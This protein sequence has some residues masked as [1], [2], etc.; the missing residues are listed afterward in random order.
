M[1]MLESNTP[2]ESPV[3]RVSVNTNTVTKV[4]I[5][6]P[7][8]FEAIRFANPPCRLR[9]PMSISCNTIVLVVGGLSAV[10]VRSVGTIILGLDVLAF[11]LVP[12]TQALVVSKDCNIFPGGRVPVG[13]V[14]TLFSALKPVTVAIIVLA[15]RHSTSTVIQSLI[16]NKEALI[17]GAQSARHIVAKGLVHSKLVH[18][19]LV[20]IH[21][22]V[23]IISTCGV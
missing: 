22:I 8:G 11:T 14:V 7:R 20:R 15:S 3:V 5:A 13:V 9:S 2:R 12:S 16:G 6:I 23:V 18:A 19:W 21:L 1:L 17:T 10:C 4:I